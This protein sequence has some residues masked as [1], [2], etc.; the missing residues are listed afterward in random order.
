MDTIEALYFENESLRQEVMRLNEII[1]SYQNKDIAINTNYKHYDNDFENE[2]Y[3]DNDDY[4][5]NNRSPQEMFED[6]VMFIDVYS[7]EAANYFTEWFRY[8]AMTDEYWIDPKE[9]ANEAEAFRIIWKNRL[10]ELT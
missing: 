10:V 4:Y 5:F 8:S 2:Y 3:N 9:E 1:I 7:P 6:Y